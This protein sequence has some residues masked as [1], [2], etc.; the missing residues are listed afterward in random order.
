MN[1]RAELDERTRGLI[2][3]IVAQTPVWPGGAQ[4]EPVVRPD[5]GADAQTLVGPP[6][7]AAMAIMVRTYALPKQPPQ[8]LQFDRYLLRY[9]GLDESKRNPDLIWGVYGTE[10]TARAGAYAALDA[11]RHG[12]RLYQ[13]DLWYRV[14]RRAHGDLTAPLTAEE[15]RQNGFLHLQRIDS[16]YRDHLR[17]I[18]LERLQ[19]EADAQIEALKLESSLEALLAQRPMLIHWLMKTCRWIMAVQHTVYI[20]SG[21]PLRVV[22][23]RRD[24][25]RYLHVGARFHPEIQTIVQQ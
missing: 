4:V 16:D 23:L 6:F 14:K 5:D 7:P 13:I 15:I 10:A 1:Y 3:S 22:T 11:R 20:G 12:R 25:S 21:V 2:D 9:N 19:E 17:S 24:P 8:H 18:L